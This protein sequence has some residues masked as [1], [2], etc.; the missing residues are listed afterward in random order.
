[1]EMLQHAIDLFL[2]LDKY[3]D[4]FIR[5]Y[6]LWVYLAMFVVVF[7]ETGLVVTPFLPGDSLLFASGALAARG[8]MS[9]AL[10]F[11]IVSA[12]AILGDTVNYWI[13][14]YFGGRIVRGEMRFLKVKQEHLDRTHAF[15]E[16]YGGKTIIIARFVPIV[17]TV[18]PFV[19][20]LGS[21]TYRK[22][23]AY[24]VIGGLMWVMVCSGG[25]Y[26][27]SD[28]PFVRDHFS[29]VIMAIIVISLIPAVVGYLQ[30]RKAPSAA[31]PEKSP[32]A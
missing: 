9:I 18:A 3:L 6:G 2:H 21:M 1:M 31:A 20:G 30:T 19:A 26:I 11:A 25:G 22:F 27:F 5:D 28:L 10:V 8:S 24:N 32:P 4:T 16:R 29:V 23:I 12:A 14:A 7:L 17:R 15:F 13:G